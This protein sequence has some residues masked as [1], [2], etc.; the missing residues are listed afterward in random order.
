MLVLSQSRNTCN[1]TSNPC[2]LIQCIPIL[3]CRITMSPTQRETLS[4]VRAP[5]EPRAGLFISRVSSRGSARKEV[6]A[7]GTARCQLNSR[8]EG[9]E[10]DCIEGES[11]FDDK[12]VMLEQLP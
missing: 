5:A 1:K 7:R 4:T 12:N 6:N 3:K 10:I 8:A 11:R 2:G 9:W